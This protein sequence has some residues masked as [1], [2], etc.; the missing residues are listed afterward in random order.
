MRDDG[1]IISYCVHH[2]WCRAE[3]GSCICKS[4]GFRPSPR[5]RRRSCRGRRRQTCAARSSC[6]LRGRRCVDAWVHAVPVLTA[7]G[8]Q[9]ALAA[10]T[11][12]AGGEESRQEVEEKAAQC[13]QPSAGRD[14]PRGARKGTLETLIRH[15]PWP[16]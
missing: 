12:V 13:A 1:A 11:R 2:G 14:C 6:C 8:I 10:V 5:Q 9:L 15:A 16:W 7:V 3:C 4:G